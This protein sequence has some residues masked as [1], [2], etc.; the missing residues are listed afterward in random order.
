MVKMHSV[1]VGD[2]LAFDSENEYNFRQRALVLVTKIHTGRWSPQGHKV[3]RMCSPD[4]LDFSGID[5]LTNE[6]DDFGIV[7][8]TEKMWTLV[9]RPD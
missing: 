8:S 5:L 1:Q 7:S 6:A 2:L 9:S 4:R 3:V